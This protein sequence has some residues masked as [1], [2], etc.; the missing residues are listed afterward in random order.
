MTA[1]INTHALLKISAA[2]RDLQEKMDC[3][4]NFFRAAEKRYNP[5]L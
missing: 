1:K 3:R 2:L 5:R 4:D